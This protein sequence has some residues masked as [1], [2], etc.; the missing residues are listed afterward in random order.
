[1]ALTLYEAGQKAL[2]IANRYSAGGYLL[3]GKR[4]QDYKNK[5]NTLANDAQQELAR[6][7]KIDG[8]HKITRNTVKPIASSSFNL[9]QHLNTDMVICGGV[10]VRAYHLMVD[11]EAT[12]YIEEETAPDVWSI[13][14]LINVPGVVSD[15][16][17]Y[18][19]I[20]TPSDDENAVRLRASGSYPYNLK[21][22]ALW[23]E[24][25]KNANTVPDYAPFVEYVLPED[26]M[27]VNENIQVN[28]ELRFALSKIDYS[29]VD[30][31]IIIPYALVGELLI[32]YFKLPTTIDENTSD[33]YEFELT[34]TLA[35]TAIPYYMA[36]VMIAEDIGD[37]SNFCMQ[38]YSE[39]IAQIERT[40]SEQENITQ[41]SNSMW[42]RRTA[43]YGNQ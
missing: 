4:V 26:F 8:I 33:N 3:A 2:K 7:S 21:N 34:N 30:L 22:C 43:C 24:L 17:K 41:V 40:E 14:A 25:F 6:V 1:M 31:K 29:K 13:L 5:R 10:G 38:R 16:V 28:D 37:M 18:K 12:I 27:G 32:Y 23:V 9:R 42:K 11:G 35:L 15:F 39:L 20:V 36:G 19:G